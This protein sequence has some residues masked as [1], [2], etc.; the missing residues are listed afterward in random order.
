MALAIAASAAVDDS[1]K[2]KRD[3]WDDLGVADDV[4]LEGLSADNHEF[5]NFPEDLEE[6]SPAVPEPQVKHIAV[7]YPVE[8]EKH[9]PVEVK[10]P[11]P[12]EIEKKVPV[13]VEKKV[14]VIVEKR[15]P[16]HIDRPVPYRVEVKV[17]VIH[18]EYVEVPRPFPVK[19]EKRIPVFLDRP[20][21]VEKT[22]P[23]TIHIQEKKKKK[24]GFPL[25]G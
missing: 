1:K 16:V 24:T 13:I 9:V 11:V 17:P 25:W 10:V 19:V 20:V 5:E 8:V 18:K 15:V 2:S 3:L 12:V 4:S 23:L 6:W 22:I 7:P 14:P 21:I